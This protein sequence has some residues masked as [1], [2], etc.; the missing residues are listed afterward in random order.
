MTAV[1][2]LLLGI[3]IV[4]GLLLDRANHIIELLEQVLRIEPF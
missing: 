3:L 1:I 2:I 4:A